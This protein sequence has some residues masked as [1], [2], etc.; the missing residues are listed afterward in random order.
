MGSFTLSLDKKYTMKAETIRNERY[1][2]LTVDDAIK[3]FLRASLD[4]AVPDA[5]VTLEEDKP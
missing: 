2:N 1:P 5:P 4:A 3:E